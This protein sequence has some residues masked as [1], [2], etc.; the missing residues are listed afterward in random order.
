MVI[1]PCSPIL[2]RSERFDKSSKR[3][4]SLLRCTDNVGTYNQSSEMTVT[5]IVMTIRVAGQPTRR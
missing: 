1:H 5:E 3:N 2:L 4:V